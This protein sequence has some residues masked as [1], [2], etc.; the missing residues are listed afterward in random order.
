M[1][2]KKDAAVT[3]LRRIFLIGVHVAYF[4]KDSCSL[5][6]KFRMNLDICNEAGDTNECANLEW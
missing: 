1:A 6:Q 4:K 2:V 5:L 3:T